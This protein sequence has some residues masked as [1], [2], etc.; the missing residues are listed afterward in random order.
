MATAKQPIFPDPPLEVGVP[1]YP[2]PN[3]PD[4]YT[5]DGHI[6][7]VEKVSA[8]KGAYNPQPLDGSVVYNKRD[9][10]KWPDTLYLVYQQPSED[11]KFVLNF[12]AN[13]RTLASQDPWNFGLDYSSNNPAFPIATRTYIVPRSQYA[14]V[15]LGSVDPVFG[16]AMRIASQKKEELPDGNPLRSRYVA[17]QRVYETIPG[18]VL[19]GTQLTE[20]GDFETVST[21]VVVAG[22]SPDGDGLLVTKTNVQAIDSVKSLKTTGTVFSYSTLTTRSKKAGLL[23]NVS[24]TDEIVSPSTA[25]DAL[26]EQIIESSVEAISAT[27]SRKRTTT[28]NGPTSL[29]GFA[30]KEGLLGEV[31]IAESIVAA[32]TSADALT[33][34]IVSSEV[35]PIDTAKSKKTLITSTGPTSLSGGTNNSGLLGKTIEQQIIVSPSATPDALSMPTTLVGGVVQSTVTPIDSGKSKKTTIISK[36]PLTL[37]GGSNKSGLLGET[38][39]EEFIVG[40]GVS[41]DALSTITNVIQSEVTPIDEV[42]SKKTTIKSSGPTSLV[43][44]EFKSGLMGV[45]VTAESIVAAGAAPDSSMAVVQSSVTPID[46]VRSK[47][48]TVVYNSP[49]TLDGK[50][51]QEFGIATAKEQIVTSATSVSPASTTIKADV[52]PIDNFKSKL[53]ELKYDSLEELNGYQYDPDLDLIIETKKTLIEEGLTPLSK[54]NG[55][56]SYRDEPI[57]AWQTVRI[58][59]KITELPPQRDEYK[60]G[61]YSSPNLITAFNINTP[62]A[63]PNWEINLQVTPVMRAKRSY[64]TVFKYETIYQYDQPEEPSDELYDP[65]T[66]NIY[67]DGIFFKISVPDALTNAGIV[68][69]FTTASN[70]P[71]HGYVSETFNVPETDESADEYIAKV[72]SYQLIGY[73]IDYWKANIWRLAKQ[74]VLLK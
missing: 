16:G 65:I 28:S 58:Q 46:N 70:D 11:G 73:E 18:P 24:T 43:G 5:K 7:L 59:S 37:S 50:S 40:A 9:A 38:T 13:D 62:A 31:T 63:M 60:T 10:G 48:T 72:G 68:V 29:S 69:G 19:T 1:Q 61:S 44:Q 34:S 45:T 53:T 2:T 56:L 22:T 54:F 15:S 23:G 47:K 12:W 49:T 4:F 8:E 21:Q 25:A 20:R 35:T 30:K 39:I 51:M 57:N 66:K 55:L 3:V 32:G 27:K 64:Q 6:V 67:F 41:A 42:K 36:G 33:Q 52:V 71:I 17:V 74:Y 26:T 14:T